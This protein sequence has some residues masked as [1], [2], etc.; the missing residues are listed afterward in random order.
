MSAKLRRAPA[1]DDLEPMEDD[2]GRHASDRGDEALDEDLS[3]EEVYA[4]VRRSW[5]LWALF[6]LALGAAVTF[7]FLW[8]QA[9]GKVRQ[10]AEV[11]SVTTRFLTAL[12]NFKAQTITA[13]AREIRAFAVGDFL[14][15]VDTFFGDKAVA[16]IRKAG[17]QST[18]TVRSV[19]LESLTADGATVFGV[20]DESVTNTS[21]PTPRT[22]LLRVEVQLIDTKSGWKVSRV[23]LLQSATSG[24]TPLG[25]G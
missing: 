24:S 20:V 6:V 18:G 1:E 16:A 2:P 8:R 23:D 7:G 14:G 19:F 17:V 11:K 12:T 22:E 3:A 15:Q 21:S 25:G 9:E 13:D 4:P 10:G 5:L